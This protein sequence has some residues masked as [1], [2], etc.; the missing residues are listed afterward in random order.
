MRI[1]SFPGRVAGAVRSGA[2]AAVSRLRAYRPRPSAEFTRAQL[3]TQLGDDYSGGQSD[4]VP[5]T[6]RRP[7]WHFT[8]LWITLTAGL[9]EL[10]LGFRY[11]QAGY[12]LAKAVVAGAVGG[13]CYL[14]YA[15]P[16]AF[17][18]SR[19]GRTTAALTRPVFGAGASRVICLGLATAAVARVVLASVLLAVVYQALFGGGQ[20]ALVAV[21]AALAGAAP[22]LLG[23]TGIAAFARYIAA[24]LL[25][26]WAGYLVARGILDTPQQV[27]SAGPA[28]SAALPFPAGVSLAIAVAAWGNEPDTWRYGRP[29]LAWPAIPYLVALATGLVLFVAGGWVVASMSHA[30]SLDLGRAL[31]SGAG[32][33]VFGALWLGAVVVTVMQLA[34]DSG[35]YYQMTNAVRGL[36]R[37]GPGAGERDSFFSGEPAPFWRREP[38]V[39]RRAWPRWPAALLLAVVSALVTWAVVTLG[40]TTSALA[41]VALWSAVALPSVVVVMCVEVFVLPRLI[42]A[43]DPGEREH[44]VSQRQDLTAPGGSAVNWAG[45]AS[46]VAAAA[47]GGYG[48]GL[49]PGQHA[50][51]M[52]GFAPLEAWLLAGVIYGAL[53]VA[54]AARAS[55]RLAPER[56]GRPEQ[57]GAAR[58]KA[59]ARVTPRALL[60]MIRSDAAAERGENQ[61]LPLIADGPA[62]RE[63]LALFALQ[64]A[65]LRSS[66]RRS[67]LYLASRSYGPASSFFAGLAE[68]ERHALDLLEVFG[69]ALTGR[70]GPPAGGDA[71]PGCQ[72]Y[73]AFVAWLALNAS[74]A[75]V[76]LA[77]T[78]NMVTWAE[79]FADL[80][81]ALRENPGF[82]LGERAFAFFD[83]IA[84]PAPQVETQALAVA[85][86][87]SDTGW[88]PDRARGY[89][90]MLRAYGQMF[91]AAAAEAPVVETPVVETP[92]VETPVVETP[93]VETPVP[94]PSTASATGRGKGRAR[95]KT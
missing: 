31:R 17:L 2:G 82:E 80:A 12:P 60:E 13:C 58:R 92:V 11:Y 63:R 66:D 81:R 37:G 89:A 6:D 91:W 56:S 55:S 73:P 77:L 35:S 23:F 18:G 87:Y 19:T 69:E 27:L 68:T 85:G 74:P 47:F 50:A 8:A 45:V 33:S 29:R 67:F 72:A 57:P 79:P 26:A 44:Q 43:R 41:R 65:R 4:P 76:A 62:A 54:R 51:P 84:T 39:S 9:A 75:D 10:A 22:G 78:A 15:L 61:F 88:P 49:L 95:Q 36:A 40:I 1:A 28:V 21:V 30:G 53:G 3:A 20:L 16:A 38:R 46:V 52:I 93:V 14:A 59:P 42:A 25:L 94:A 71:L 90:R 7:L 5:D 70:K 48:L 86:A 64:Q 24:P 32:Y 83:L 34:R